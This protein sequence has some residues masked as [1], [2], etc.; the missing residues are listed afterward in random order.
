MADKSTI[1]RASVNLSDVDRG[2]YTELKTTL[3]RHPSETAERLTTRLLAY[4][5]NYGE[6]L[7]FTKGICDGD[8][9]D[10]WI[11]EDHRI[12]HWFEVGQPDPE[13]LRNA[14]KKSDRVTLYL[15]GRRQRQWQQM[16]LPVLSELSNLEIWSLDDEFLEG[17]TA[18]LERDIRWELTRSDGGIYLTLGDQTLE[19]ELRRVL[20]L[21]D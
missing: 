10:L 2:I 7:E 4:A 14:C 15:Y 8:T 11:R 1:H 17:L 18:G 13:R 19:T 12:L 20:P 16:H 9:P 6:A 5:L 21:S 3:A